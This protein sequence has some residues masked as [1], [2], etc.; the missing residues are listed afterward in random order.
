MSNIVIICKYSFIQR[1]KYRSMHKIVQNN[2][3]R[4]LTYVI[5]RDSSLK[6]YI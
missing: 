2:N 6:L 5:W 4:S 1:E 3:F